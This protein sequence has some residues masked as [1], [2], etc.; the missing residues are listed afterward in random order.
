MKKTLFTTAAALVFTAL[1]AVTASAQIEVGP[2]AGINF[3]GTEIL[4]G[5][6]GRFP[7]GA[8][9]AGLPIIAKPGIEFYPF[10]GGDGG[11][12]GNDNV[13]VSLWVVNAD[14][15]V[16]LDLTDS[17]Q[18]YAG[19]GLY[20]SRYSINFNANIPGFDFDDSSTD[21]GLNVLAGATFG[22][23]SKK[24]VP[25]AEAVLALGDGGS[26]FVA[27]GGLLFRLGG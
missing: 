12:S 13:D 11:L 20:V 15:I 9:V 18:A 27:K 7:V 25:F 14:V 22:D 1:L 19:A 4:I 6:Q 17:F 24:M 3:D 16:P 26:G 23:E 8:E 5:A 21:I 10:I 2:L